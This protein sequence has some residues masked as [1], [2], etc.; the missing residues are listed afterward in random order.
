M[1]YRGGG[2]I[3]PGGMWTPTETLL[4]WLVW[5]PPPALAEAALDELEESRH[6]R[7]HLNHIWVMPRLMTHCWQKQLSKICDLVFSIPPG[8]RPFWPA[9]GHEPLIIGLTLRFSVSSPWQTKFTT[10][11]LEVERALSQVWSALDEPERHILF[12]FC[13]TPERLDGLSKCMV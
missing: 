12:E 7:K 4:T 10:G 13:V 11:V 9:V 6:K 5:S 2:V 8:A 3:G 1:A